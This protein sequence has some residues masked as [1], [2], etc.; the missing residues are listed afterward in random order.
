M[1]LPSIPSTSITVFALS[2]A[3]TG[4]TKLT[5]YNDYMLRVV[6]SS[7]GT[8]GST[9]FST[10]FSSAV[11]TSATR[12]FTALTLAPTSANSPTHT[13]PSGS[14]AI[15]GSPGSPAG[16]N[17]AGGPTVA[18][19][20]YTYDDNPSDGSTDSSG[21]GSGH[22]HTTAMPATLRGPTSVPAT[23]LNFSINYLDLILAQRN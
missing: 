11:S 21:S 9:A 1:S 14:P 3:L 6:S 22:T 15:I 10:V 17:D 5:T 20:V 2:A 4:W 12:T 23:T 7:P 19:T 16:V 13:H 18:P 8:G